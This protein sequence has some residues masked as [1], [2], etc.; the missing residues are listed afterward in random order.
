MTVDLESPMPYAIEMET[1]VFAAYGG[2]MATIA[3]L[4]RNLHIVQVNKRIALARK[5]GRVLAVDPF[6]KAA[7]MGFQELVNMVAP[8]CDP[9]PSLASDLT[10]AVKR[11]NY[12]CHDFWY[13]NVNAMLTEESRR[14]LLAELVRDAET[15][16]DIND[17]LVQ[18]VVDPSM[19]ALGLDPEE[20]MWIALAFL[21]AHAEENK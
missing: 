3:T 5:E 21:K 8:R 12:L 6:L 7:R 2:V 11:R 15:F 19:K 9:D 18:T 13:E 17:R 20:G 4:E 1:A 10:S 14:V 16:E